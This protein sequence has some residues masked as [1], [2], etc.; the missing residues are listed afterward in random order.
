MIGL[1][2][3]M[4]FEATTKY[5]R[6]LNES[7][8]DRVHPMASAELILYSVDFKRVVELQQSGRWVD[9]GDY[10]AKAAR[11]IELAGAECMLIC[12]NTMH[13]V[14]DQV[15]KAIGVPLIHIIDVTADELRKGG[16]KKPLLLAT[17][18]TMEHGF[19]QKRMSTHNIEVIVP[20]EGGRAKLHSIIFN[21]LVVRKVLDSSREEL[22]KLIEQAKA[23]GADSVIFGCTEIGMILKP[24]GLALPGFDSTVI[25][26]NAAIE[27]ALANK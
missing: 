1:L 8:R 3:G 7:I 10:L 4:S 13:I 5:Y 9:A 15:E 20:N 18:Y 25:H 11:G 26:C 6:Y 2:G 23:E 19:Y 22:N 21:E 17:K 24:Q 12:A 27:F 14:S 16:F